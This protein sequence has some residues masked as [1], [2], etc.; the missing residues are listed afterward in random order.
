MKS[1][2]E[3]YTQSYHILKNEYKLIIKKCAMLHLSSYYKSWQMSSRVCL[4]FFIVIVQHQRRLLRFRYYMN[5]KLYHHK[6]LWKMFTPVL[7]ALGF[8]WSEHVENIWWIM[9]NNE[10][11]KRHKSENF[12]AHLP[13]SSM[14]RWW[15]CVSR[16]QSWAALLDAHG[17]S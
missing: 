5:V 4:S 9:P 2:A 6:K 8:N 10:W 12:S 14:E 11:E 7:V 3:H 13:L 16:N 17:N 1:L 15:L